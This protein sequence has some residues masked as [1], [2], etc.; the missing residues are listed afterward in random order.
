MSTKSNLTNNPKTY[1]IACFGIH[2]FSICP[3]ILHCL[4]R[5]GSRLTV[6]R[7]GFR[8]LAVTIVT[9]GF[10]G[11]LMYM[12]STILANCIEL[13]IACRKPKQYRTRKIA[14]PDGIITNNAK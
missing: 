10:L 3:D 12:R 8:L 9:N 2:R 14:P 6:S 7:L 1:L 4:F 11:L 13:E 5:A